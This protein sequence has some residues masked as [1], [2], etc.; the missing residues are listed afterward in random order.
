VE[1]Y[2]KLYKGTNDKEEK[3]ILKNIDIA[4]KKME[5]KITKYNIS[6]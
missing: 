4:M 2:R 1:K 6:S 3:S 5:E